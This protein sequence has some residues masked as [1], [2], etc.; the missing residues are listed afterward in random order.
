M[1]MKTHQCEAATNPALQ[2]DDAFR[3][4]LHSACPGAYR[5]APTMAVQSCSCDCH[6]KAAKAGEADPSGASFPILVADPG[7]EPR[8]DGET[9]K[10]ERE[11]PRAHSKPVD[12]CEQRVQQ[13]TRERD[14]A[15]G[16]A[17]EWEAAARGHVDYIAMLKE[18]TE[19]LRVVLDKLIER[20]Q[21]ATSREEGS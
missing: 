3:D 11:R 1:A 19:R 14:R 15:E 7:Q 5:L 21:A 2:M 12:D 6:A 9:R 8:G 13:L 18:E 4:S 10:K 16:A 20:L 17:A